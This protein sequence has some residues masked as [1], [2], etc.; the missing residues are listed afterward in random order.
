MINFVRMTEPSYNSIGDSFIEPVVKYLESFTISDR[1]LLGATNV[2]MTMQEDY[3]QKVGLLGK[4]VLLPNG[5]A[6][7]GIRD[8]KDIFMFDRVIV[9]G[10]AWVSKLANQGMSRQKIFVGGYPKLDAVTKVKRDDTNTVL[11]AP[12]HSLS[13]GSTYPLLQP[14]VESLNHKVIISTH[15]YDRVCKVPTFDAL[16]QARV[17]I[18]DVGSTVYEAMALG[19][20]VV[21]ADWLMKDMILRLLPDSFE[22]ALFNKNI[23]YH[24]SN[25]E[26]F[27]NMVNEAYSAQ[28][29][30]F[31]AKKFIDGILPAS[32]VGKS[33]KKIA[34]YLTMLDQTTN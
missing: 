15:P 30:G 27:I 33:G 28:N 2:H 3:I 8:Y 23:G 1:T 12:T 13:A 14:L 20:P 24:A 21:F 19:V 17:V 5:I 25:E 34:D 10:P 16:T 9:S 4:N 6:D 32:L 26:Q 22:A 7:K 11:W 29:L 18:A 31:K